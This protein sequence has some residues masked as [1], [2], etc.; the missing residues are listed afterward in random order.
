MS[1]HPPIPKA[2]ELQSNVKMV[3]CCITK[4]LPPHLRVLED[5]CSNTS[6]LTS[7]LSPSRTS[8]PSQLAIS[9]ANIQRTQGHNLVSA[10][11]LVRVHMSM[12]CSG[13]ASCLPAMF[14]ANVVPSTCDGLQPLS[15][16]CSLGQG[17]SLQPKRYGEHPAGT[18]RSNCSSLKTRDLI[19]H[20]ATLCGGAA[21]DDKAS[22]MTSGASV[23]LSDC[24]V[25]S[26]KLSFVHIEK[27][28]LNRVERSNLTYCSKLCQWYMQGSLFPN[29]A[30]LLFELE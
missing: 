24:T 19:K 5:I 17:D 27:G 9:G 14:M 26:G 8:S 20:C 10:T 3:T 12:H 18:E 1:H 21:I 2:W 30:F 13:Y 16:A 6:P 23:H 4:L 11:I 15:F 28:T 22:S 29:M 7:F 25:F